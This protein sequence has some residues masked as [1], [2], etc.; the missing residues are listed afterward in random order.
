MKLSKIKSTAFLYAL[1]GALSRGFSLELSIEMLSKVQPKPINKYLENIVF[2]VKKK[3]EKIPNLL[4]KFGFITQ[5]EKIILE[6]A[7]DTKFAINSIIEMRKIDGLFLKSFFKVVTLPFLALIFA[8][9]GVKKLLENI[10]PI[11]SQMFYMLKAKG[12]EPSF[13]MLGIPKM[14]YFLWDRKI[15]DY[16]TFTSAVVFIFIIVFIFFTRTYK[17][18]ILY[19]LLPPASYDDMPY[20]LSYMAS[21]NKVGYPAEKVADILAKSN[22][23]PGWKE[24]FLRIKENIKKGGK[25]YT[26]FERMCFPKEIVTYI[27][28]DELSGD[29]W[30]NIEEI[31]NLSI[32]RNKQ[33]SEFFTGQIKPVSTI[34]T[35]MIIFYF[36][37]GILMLNLSLTNIGNLIAN[38]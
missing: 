23:R 22:L 25:I 26:E 3:N 35:Y 13:E 37:V 17:P 24:M 21:L 33:I 30:G 8:P 27:K 4:H 36:I 7:Q 38:S 11:L 10:D 28:Y 20:I 2:L 14:F 15:L 31:K 6:K 34:L 16:V 29:F 19:K 9:L 1:K 18:S 5:E 32:E 12:I